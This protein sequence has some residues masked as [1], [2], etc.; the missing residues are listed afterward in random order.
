MRIVGGSHRGRPLEAPPGTTTRPTSDRVRQSLFDLLGQRCDELR[1][2]DLYAG[3][4]AL[5]LEALSRGATHAT[6]IERDRAA[7]TALEHNL[8]ALKLADRCTVL[9]DDV[10]R[11]LGQLAQRPERFDLV[12]C[13]PPYALKAS[14]GTLDS[15]ARLGLVNPQGRVVLEGDDTEP[16]LVLPEGFTLTTDRMYGDTRIRILRVVPLDLPTPEHLP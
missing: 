5:A 14:Q 13:D 1:V 2:L 7:L 15:L 8:Q 11:A 6:L 16:E 3:T 10:A 4:G 9:K 12:L